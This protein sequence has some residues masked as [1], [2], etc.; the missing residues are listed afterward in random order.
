M[1]D[2]K[3]SYETLQNEVAR[4]R[5]LNTTLEDE[6]DLL[7]LQYHKLEEQM[8]QFSALLENSSDFI[9]MADFQGNIIYLNKGGQNMVGIDTQEEVAKTNIQNYLFPEDA[10]YVVR[11]VLP[12]L[13]EKGQWKKEFRFRHFKTGQPIAVDYTLFVLK[14]ETTG[15][16]IALGTVTRDISEAKA[17]A[18]HQQRLI[19]VIENSSD[20]IGIADQEG[21]ALYVNE[22]GRKMIGLESDEE[23]KNTNI[24]SYFSPE[25]LEIAHREI[26]PTVLEKGRW[27]GEFRFRHFKTGKTIPVSYNLFAVRD[28]ETQE[29]IALSTVSRD[30]S[31]QQEREQAL[32]TFLALTEN[33]PDGVAVASLEGVITYANNEYHSL[34]GYAKDEMNGTHI[35]RL[36]GG[37]DSELDGI[38]KE[39]F[40]EGFWYGIWPFVRKDGS[41]FSGQVS[42]FLI[43]SEDGEAFSLG[44]IMR[45]ITAQLQAEEE[46]SRLQEQVIQAQRAAIRELGTPLIPLAEQIVAMPLVGTID[47]SR[48]QQIMET[49]LEGCSKHQA[50]VVI[51]DITGVKVVDSQV[52]DAL[53]RTARAASLL[54]SEVVITGIS[55]EIAQTLVQIGIDLGT[56]VTR[57]TLQ[58][59]IQYALQ[60]RNLTFDDSSKA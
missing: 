33:A 6:R 57:A 29:I 45:D 13:M 39:T 37:D 14:D 9:G 47:T 7:K 16:P 24:Q 56:I 11:E 32:R 59:G 55:P 25:D 22:A 21:N 12:I 5:E 2:M 36:F 52:A 1:S 28:K 4:L 58:S 46:R 50:E 10:E 41:T 31:E 60:T 20:F 44:F 35:K 49:L 38:L 18:E 53:V 26:M 51:L 43:R 17:I 34:T 3:E 8:R 48:A 30:I 15:E 23:V 40:E 54:G 27:V 19:A 42:C